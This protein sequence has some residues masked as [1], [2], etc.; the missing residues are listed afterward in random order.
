MVVSCGHNSKA[1]VGTR[2]LAVAS[3]APL[4]CSLGMFPALH[5]G[6]PRQDKNLITIVT[7]VK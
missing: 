7:I 6:R 5:L 3:P 2:D 4:K 1:H